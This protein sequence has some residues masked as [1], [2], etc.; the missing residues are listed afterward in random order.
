MILKTG[1]HSIHILN[2]VKGVQV[3]CNKWNI[4]K[5]PNCAQTSTIKSQ[6][7]LRVDWQE[8]RG[9]IFLFERA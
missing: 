8:L 4:F 9:K 2:D 5:I 7:L 6:L 1:M 3:H